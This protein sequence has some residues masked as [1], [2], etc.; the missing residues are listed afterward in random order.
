MLLLHIRWLLI[1]LKQ[2]RYSGIH[3]YKPVT[4]ASCGN[5][6]IQI[7]DINGDDSHYLL[8]ST[9]WLHFISR[10]PL[11][12]YFIL[13]TALLER[14]YYPNCADEKTNAVWFRV[15]QLASGRASSAT[16]VRFS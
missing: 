8:S 11:S 14:H 3:I 6:T 10:F 5:T 4:V 13:I 15:T 16:F 12:K 1:G 7:D 9:M 2:E